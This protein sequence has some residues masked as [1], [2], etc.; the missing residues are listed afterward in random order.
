M[1][2]PNEFVSQHELSNLLTYLLLVIQ[3]SHTGLTKK[4]FCTDLKDGAFTYNVDIIKRKF[5]MPIQRADMKVS[6]PIYNLST[7]CLA[8][9]P[10]KIGIKPL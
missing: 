9:V 3:H 2:K 6:N 10:S 5:F 1:F 7:L 4:L 8:H